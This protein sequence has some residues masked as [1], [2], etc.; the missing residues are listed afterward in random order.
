MKRAIKLIT[1]FKYNEVNESVFTNEIQCLLKTLTNESNVDAIRYCVEQIKALPN[2]IIIDN[3]S[4]VSAVKL[5][6]KADSKK[7]VTLL[8]GLY[9]KDSRFYRESIRTAIRSSNVDVTEILISELPADLKTRC[10]SYIITRGVDN[11]STQALIDLFKL[12]IIS[13]SDEDKSKLYLQA[14]R[15]KSKI[16]ISYFVDNH[17]NIILNNPTAFEYFCKEELSSNELISILLESGIQIS[18]IRSQTWLRILLLRHRV[19]NKTLNLTEDNNITYLLNRNSLKTYLSDKTL[20]CFINQVSSLL[21]N[22]EDK[23]VT[24][25]NTLVWLLREDLI[26]SNVV[27]NKFLSTF[28]YEH[29]VSDNDKADFLW[30]KCKEANLSKVSSLCCILAVR[31]GILDKFSYKCSTNK[32]NTLMLIHTLR[33]A[34]NVAPLELLEYFPDYTNLI[35]EMIS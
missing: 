26:D 14:L 3:Q 16:F 11:N 18:T 6:N 13:E 8:S 1:A 21:T 28:N 7:I 30:Q 22:V 31:C 24:E 29:L 15:K 35:F 5:K 2:Y 27:M 17:P 33:G 25:I 9:V 32:N 19:H 4:I 34:H 12:H 20:D 10:L 23:S